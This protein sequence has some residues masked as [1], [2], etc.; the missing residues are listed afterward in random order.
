MVKSMSMMGY[1]DMLNDTMNDMIGDEEDD[2]MVVYVDNGPVA[3]KR[4]K[5][6]ALWTFFVSKYT[7]YDDMFAVGQTL[8]AIFCI[9]VASVLMVS[10]FEFYM[11]IFTIFAMAVVYALVYGS[12]DKK[13]KYKKYIE[14]NKDL[15]NIVFNGRK[16]GFIK[17]SL[18][19]ASEKA[20]KKVTKEEVREEKE[21]NNRDFLQSVSNAASYKELIKS[22]N[23]VISADYVIAK[24]Y[25]ENVNSAIAVPRSKIEAMVFGEVKVGKFKKYHTLA[26]RLLDGQIIE[27]I[28]GR[29]LSKSFANKV[30]RIMYSKKDDTVKEIAKVK[31]R[32]LIRN[33][34]KVSWAPLTMASLWV[35]GNFVKL[36]SIDGYIVSRF[37]SVIF[38]FVS[39]GCC[40][41]FIPKIVKLAKEKKAIEKDDNIELEMN[42]LS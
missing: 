1:N 10:F 14:T 6:D 37:F 8:F 21:K 31:Q 23:I 35:F 22:K 32:Y 15:N 42:V 26:L 29:R 36:T 13:I 34:S 12:F 25:A 19:D 9:V 3:Q 27:C 33:I 5:N 40:C 28:I 17:E 20:K 16:F 7:K 30:R 24:G 11:S 38:F 18:R 39:I 2:E 4:A 41:S